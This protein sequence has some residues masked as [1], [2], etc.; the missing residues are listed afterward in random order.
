MVESLRITL[1]FRA[2]AGSA[3]ALQACRLVMALEEVRRAS[4][5]QTIVVR[6]QDAQL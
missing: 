2:L 3:E 6:R 5:L 4:A 1:V